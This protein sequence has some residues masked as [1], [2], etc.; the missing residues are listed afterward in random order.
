MGCPAQWTNG[1]NPDEVK[2]A[3]SADQQ[4]DILTQALQQRFECDTELLQELVTDTSPAP[5][6]TSNLEVS[7]V[8]PVEP[9]RNVEVPE[10]SPVTPNLSASSSETPTSSL[11][12]LTLWSS[13]SESRI[14]EDEG[15]TLTE[16]ELGE[17]RGIVPTSNQG[18]GNIERHP[19]KVSICNKKHAH[20]P[21]FHFIL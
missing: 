15:S 9:A 3:P 18:A 2:S 19:L 16:T 11:P 6:P 17:I 21:L 13:L 8:S 1:N 10:V 14:R 4:S 20:G 12:I 7:N 5:I